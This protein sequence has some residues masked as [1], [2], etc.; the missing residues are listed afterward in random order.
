M[1]HDRNGK[2]RMVGRF[3][4]RNTLAVGD[5]LWAYCTFHITS[6]AL[7]HASKVLSGWGSLP[8]E[9]L[10]QQNSFLECVARVASTLKTVHLCWRFIDSSFLGTAK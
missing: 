4:L 2:V 5:I 8:P 6:H 3:L 10:E 1:V 7:S 9:F